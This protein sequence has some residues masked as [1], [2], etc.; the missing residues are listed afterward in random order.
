M[1]LL[2]CFVAVVVDRVGGV[3]LKW[4]VVVAFAMVLALAVVFVVPVVVVV[5]A[6][7]V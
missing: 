2:L 4:L 7:V 1:L 5:P 3:W 6:L